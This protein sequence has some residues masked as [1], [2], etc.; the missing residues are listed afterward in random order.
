MK[1]KLLFGSLGC[2]LMFASCQK[3]E[4]EEVQVKDSQDYYCSFADEGD[5]E[6]FKTDAAINKYA[7]WKPGATI[8]IKFLG[9]T[10]FQQGKVKLYAVEWLKYANLVF[11]WVGASEVADIKIA[12]NSSDASWSYLGTRCTY[13]GQTTP[14][15]NFSSINTTIGDVSIKS[16][17]LHE[18]GHALGLVHEHQSP[19]AQISWNTDAVY[20]EF[21]SAPYNWSK[22]KVDS[23]ILKKELRQSTNYTSFDQN[24]IMLYKYP[25]YLTTNGWS[26]PNNT[27]LSDLDKK[28]IGINYP[29]ST[30]PP[31]KILYNGAS[32]IGV[33]ANGTVW[34]LSNVLEPGG[35][36]GI[37]KYNGISFN[38]VSGAAIAIDV[39]P[40]GNAWI[41]YRDG[42]IFKSNS[43]NQFT[44]IP[45]TAKDIGVGADGKVFIIGTNVEVGGYGIYQW[46]GSSWIKIPGAAVR[47]SVDNEGY[48]WVVNNAGDIYRYNGS[49]WSG[50]SSYGYDIGCG[51]DGSVYAST[52]L[53]AINGYIIMK[54]TANG[55]IKFGEAATKIDAG[56]NGVLYALRSDGSVVQY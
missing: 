16:A 12:F 6:S 55:W 7:L 5:Q 54:Y 46:S 52:R 50:L 3:K 1:K 13:Y 10:T 9:G 49:K 40:E 43:L 19:S 36:Y 11:Q 31:S 8:K 24:S 53:A 32:D 44:R 23:L 47:I 26:A 42:S 4:V 28:Y 22:W 41:V 20:K 33:G 18:F 25:S 39:D 2:F 38:K 27:V 14:T 45:G 48:P 51:A 17:V 30:F 56:P 37:Y 15:M 34:V 21:T 29:F 35:G